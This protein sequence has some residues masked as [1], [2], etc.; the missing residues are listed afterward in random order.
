MSDVIRHRIA[1]LQH[2]RKQRASHE[3]LSRISDELSEP[4][5]DPVDPGVS[6]R[7]QSNLYAKLKELRTQNALRQ[8]SFAD[9]EDAI[10][11]VLQRSKLLGS[12]AVF[13][14]YAETSGSGFF[15]GPLS[16]AFVKA[17]LRQHEGLAAV[18]LGL[19]SGAVLDIALDDPLRGNFYEVEWWP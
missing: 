6:L 17:C 14:V 2:Q 16:S 3:A 13:E 11:E 18:L 1:V 5:H 19:E 15:A 10:A 12:S 8:S 7:L 4:R 9:V